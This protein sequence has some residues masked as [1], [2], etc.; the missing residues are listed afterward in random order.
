MGPRT[1]LE[2]ESLSGISIKKTTEQ[3]SR[4]DGGRVRRGYHLPSHRYIRNTSTCGTAP[5][6]HPLN[7]GRR[8]QIS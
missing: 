2:A 5:T 3:G 4:Q 7:A 8:H 6:E 1:Q